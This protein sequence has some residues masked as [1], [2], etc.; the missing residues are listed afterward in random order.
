MLT[1][2]QKTQTSIQERRKESLQLIKD[3][4]KT[5]TEVLA[6][7]SRLAGN[8][9]FDGNANQEIFDLLEEFC[10]LLIDY[11]ANAHFRLYRFIDDN[12]EKRKA[13]FE[14]A[15][16]TY[17]RI[18]EITQTILDFNDKYDPQGNRDHGNSL[19][20]LEK[21]LSTLG[22]QMA[23]R[24]ELEDQIIEAMSAGRVRH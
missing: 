23:E 8:K 16:K 20:G 18:R 15:D 17:P 22:E 3:L 2:N 11:T 21:D 14:V 4:I 5:R 6:L 12:K 24:I 9:P 10:E 13:V 19:N 7:Y 1:E